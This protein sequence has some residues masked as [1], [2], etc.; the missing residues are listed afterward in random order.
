MQLKESL[1]KDNNICSICG[2][3]IQEID[4]SAI[5]HIIQYW[6]GGQTIPENAQL[7]HRYCNWAK[8][9]KDSPQ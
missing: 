1:F 3:K 6:T 7:A 2:Q 8:P 5:D 9:R 4:D